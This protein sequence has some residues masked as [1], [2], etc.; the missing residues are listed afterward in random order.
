MTMAALHSLM[1]EDRAE[2]KRDLAEARAQAQHL[3]FKLAELE[4]E[5]A[6]HS[7][8]GKLRYQLSAQERW[9]AKY[10]RWLTADEA[11]A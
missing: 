1:P 8:R 9:I 5:Q 7:Y 6:P 2:V 3:R 4:R 10:E 11:A